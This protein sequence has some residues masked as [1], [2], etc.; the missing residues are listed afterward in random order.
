ME[1]NFVEYKYGTS[2]GGCGGA[3]NRQNIVYASKPVKAQVD[4]MIKL[5][6]TSQDIKKLYFDNQSLANKFYADLTGFQA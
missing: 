1:N 4:W 5:H 2:D 3:F 6:Y